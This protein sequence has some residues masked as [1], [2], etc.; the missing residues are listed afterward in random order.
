MLRIERL[1][2][3]LFAVL[4][5]AITFVAYTAYER[6][7]PGGVQAFQV[8]AVPADTAKTSLLVAL[9]QEASQCQCVI[10]KPAANPDGSGGRVIY[11]FNG[12]GQAAQSYGDFSRGPATRLLDGAELE[13]RDLRGIYTVSRPLARVIAA[14]LMAQGIVAGP[15]FEDTFEALAPIFSDAA[16]WSTIAAASL[17]LFAAVA[18]GT[19]KRRLRDAVWAANGRPA[20]DRYA[21]DAADFAITAAAAGAGVMAAGLIFLGWYNQWHQVGSFLRWTA[22]AMLAVVVIAVAI[23]GL[24]YL[25]RPPLAL[26]KVLHGEHPAVYAAVA[27]V[28]AQVL[29]LT[30]AMVSVGS[31]TSGLDRLEGL[32]RFE[33]DWRAAS[34]LVLIQSDAMG[35]S[36]GQH[37]ADGGT[38]FA[39][40]EE[41]AGRAVLAAHESVASAPGFEVVVGSG[42]TLLVNPVFLAREL[43]R[44]IAGKEIDPSK[45]TTFQVLIPE[46]LAA[47]AQVYQAAGTEFAEYEALE[48]QD[49]DYAPGIGLKP[50]VVLVESGQM[51]FTLTH[52]AAHE[53]LAWVDPVLYVVPLNLGLISPIN[54]RNHMLNGRLLFSD[55]ARLQTVLDSGLHSD[56]RPEIASLADLAFE[57]IAEQ[58]RQAWTAAAGIV[59]ALAALLLAITVFAASDCLRN[60]QEFFAR[61]IHG[62]RSLLLALPNTVLSLGAGAAALGL[63][64]AT[65]QFN[66]SRAIWLCAA[67]VVLAGAATFFITLLFLNRRKAEW[68]KQY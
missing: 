27:S 61:L 62:R 41:A 31:L 42:S 49:R 46:H 37:A 34:D 59:L 63:A 8:T 18:Y 1:A 25:V 21:R 48:L 12:T 60:R 17:G 50:E 15:L 26:V 56:C 57:Q 11:S 20:L 36:S 13:F 64:Y 2:L 40:A 44:D 35:P 3:V 54:L 39:I 67:L 43:V 28:T 7:A 33:P 14:N 52:P 4:A 66:A 10:L 38:A 58:R 29:V 51:V 68:L 65:G 47:Y 9:Q 45:I 32:R 6:L 53:P 5:F 30:M 23:H 55:S 19:V 24:T 16:L 22:F